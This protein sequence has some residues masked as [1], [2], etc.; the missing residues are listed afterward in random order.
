MREKIFLRAGFRW[1]DNA[2]VGPTGLLRARET[3]FPAGLIIVIRE[4]GYRELKGFRSKDSESYLRHD[5]NE[6]GSASKAVKNC[7]AFFKALPPITIGVDPASADG[8]HSAVVARKGKKVIQH[9]NVGCSHSPALEYTKG[10]DT[11]WNVYSSPK[12]Y[13]NRYRKEALPVKP[14]KLIARECQE[15]IDFYEISKTLTRDRPIAI[16]QS[17]V[18]EGYVVVHKQLIRQSFHKKGFELPGDFRPNSFKLKFGDC[19][20]FPL[21][22]PSQIPAW[23]KWAKE[24]RQ[25]AW[26]SPKRTYEVS[27]PEV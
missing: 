1:S 7:V 16:I 13:P 27:F 18:E 10:E 12:F 8:D 9:I 5:G 17:G 24:V 15:S 2:Y 21:P 11:T 25:L 4:D 14:Y 22:H 23:L 6:Y 26:E 20:V 3:F 19:W